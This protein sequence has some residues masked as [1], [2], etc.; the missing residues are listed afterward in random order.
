[1]Q[2]VRRLLL[3]RI[4]LLLPGVAACDTAAPAS[5]GRAGLATCCAACHGDA[6]G[7][8]GPAS[9]TLARTPPDLTTLSRRNGGAV[10]GTRVMARVWGKGG[11]PAHATGIM[12]GFGPLLDGEPVPCDGGDGLEAPT[13]VRLVQGAEH[14]RSLRQP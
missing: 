7:G 4:P 1:V 13:P 2:A 12:P 11:G 10:P 6:A 8:G 3:W 9:P 5:S 14:L